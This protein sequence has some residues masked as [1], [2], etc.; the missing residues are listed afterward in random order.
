M[1]VDPSGAVVTAREANRLVLNPPTMT[2]R[3]LL[4]RGPGG[5]DLDVDRPE[6][7][8]LVDV[9]IW[10]DRLQTRVSDRAADDWYS[11]VIGRPLR[12]VY[13]DDPR[14]RR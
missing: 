6:S 7:G 12:L 4:R 13:L 5:E 2:D 10:D 9:K 8:P 1:L 14:R 11:R 3:G